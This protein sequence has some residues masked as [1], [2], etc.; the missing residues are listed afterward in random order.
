MGCIKTDK[1]LL[2]VDFQFEI[3]PGW[4]ID[5]KVESS[6]IKYMLTHGKKSMTFHSA[7]VKDL[8]SRNY[9]IRL[10]KGRRQMILT[11]QVLQGLVDFETFLNWYD[12]ALISQPI[13][14][15]LP[16]RVT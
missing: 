10:A 13:R 11:L 2:P 15:Q 6:P 3:S 8:C 14:C 16:P 1:V 5:I 7:V 9:G 12:S 4:F